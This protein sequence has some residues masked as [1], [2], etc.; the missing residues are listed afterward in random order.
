MTRAGCHVVNGSHRGQSA[1]K[2]LLHVLLSILPKC[3]IIC[4]WSGGN[5]F[6]WSISS[7]RS[8]T[9]SFS[10]WKNKSTPQGALADTPDW[11][12]VVSG[13][14]KG[15]RKRL[16]L[17]RIE[18]FDPRFTSHERESSQNVIMSTEDISFICWLWIGAFWPIWSDGCGCHG[19]AW[20]CAYRM[21]HVSQ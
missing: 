6:H 19:W 2:W 18:S 12:P 8:Y 21:L 7:Q 15:S 16:S 1:C 14:G 4:V 20:V 11:Q 13:T 5:V 17:P 10:C 3:S 9:M